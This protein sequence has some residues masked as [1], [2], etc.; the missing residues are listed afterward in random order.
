M[1]LAAFSCAVAAMIL[2]FVCLAG[3]MLVRAHQYDQQAGR[4][5]LQQRQSYQ[6]AIGTLPDGANIRA[7]MVSEERRLAALSGVAG[8]DASALFPP[9]STLV[10]LADTLKS[11]PRNIRYRLLDIRLS[12]NDLVLN[13]ETRTHSDVDA[14]AQGL[15]SIGGYAVDAPHSETR[16]DN[17]GVTFTVAAQVIQMPAASGRER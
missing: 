15:R 6:Q 16:G 1:I 5:E 9:R 11:L 7:R 12:S 3:A 14:I 17:R 10:I 13:G 8:N 2:F 4:A